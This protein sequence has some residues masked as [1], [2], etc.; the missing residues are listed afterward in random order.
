MANR[1]RFY[2]AIALLMI[3]TFS[4]CAWYGGYGYYDS[5]HGYRGYG[6]FDYHDDHSYRH[7]HHGDRDRY[8]RWK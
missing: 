2:I 5:P 4:G 6:R 3:L 1:N 7:D 8:P